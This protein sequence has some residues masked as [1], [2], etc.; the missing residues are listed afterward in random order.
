MADLKLFGLWWWF[1][2]TVSGM[3]FLLCSGNDNKHIR[4]QTVQT[5]SGKI[6]GAIV[7]TETGHEVVQYLGVPYGTPPV[8]DL[9]FKLPRQV[10]PWSG[11]FHADKLAAACYQWKDDTFPGFN[12]SELWN[13]N[14]PMSEDCLNLN[15]WVPKGATNAT[16]LVWIYGGSF[17]YG[18][19]SLDM[20]HGD[21]LATE[22]NVIV[23][24]IN[25]RLGVFGF[26]YLDDDLENAPGNMGLADQQLA[27]KWIKR[28]I[29][30]FG[31][32]P[33]KI[34][35]FGE[36]AGAA[37]VSSHLL[38]EN[39]WDLFRYAI[40]QSGTI[41]EPWGAKTPQTIVG[42]SRKV[43]EILNCSRISS[44]DTVA[45]LRTVN[46]SKLQYAQDQMS[47]NLSFLE[48][49]F[50]PITKDIHFFR[51]DV[52]DKLKSGNFKKTSVLLGTNSDEG[53][54]WLP[55]YL[56]D[57]FTHTSEGLINRNEYLIS[58]GK[59]FP[60]H[61][62]LI[63]NAIG[64]HYSTSSAQASG[65]TT[66]FSPNDKSTFY[67]DLI[68]K[69]VG[70]YFFTCK[71]ISTAD[72]FNQ[73]GSIVYMYYFTERVKTN[74]WPIWMGVMHAYEIEYVFGLPLKKPQEYTPREVTF[75]SNIMRFWVNFAK[76]GCV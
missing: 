63:R 19:P 31:G 9:R 15:I 69:I 60:N 53:S 40:L 58:I 55:Y 24:N 36:S 25:Y 47:L 27:L 44:R 38:S 28:N 73:H 26:L 33:N 46:L 51:G 3:P 39:S 76:T 71:V 66:P 48:F 65:L 57:Y 16:V 35:L 74:P 67:R 61:S 50:G 23:V 4:H 52:K 72:T 2:W 42:Q 32:E 49:P 21:I 56:S 20:Y 1:V 7:R 5:S 6:K 68:S 11:V 34:T 14:T 54:F 70:D 30:N 29:R 64:Y 62:K 17:I 41:I 13:A 10:E 75:S 8:G 43:A 18:S 59:A 45:C 37:G 12:G 22:G